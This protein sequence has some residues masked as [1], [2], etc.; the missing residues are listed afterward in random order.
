MALPVEFNTGIVEA[1]YVDLAGNPMVG[2]V[3]FS[4]SPEVLIAATSEVIVVP[5]VR[6]V[7]LDSNGHFYLELPGTDDPDIN[8]TDWT[9]RVNEV[10]PG[11]TRTYDIKVPIGQA[12]DLSTESP[13]ASANGVVITRGLTGAT[14]EGYGGG[15]IVVPPNMDWTD[16]LNLVISS[17]WGLRDDGTVYYDPQGADP[18]EAALLVPNPL[19]GQL[20]VFRPGFPYVGPVPN[21]LSNVELDTRLDDLEAVTLDPRLTALEDQHLD[22][23]LVVVSE[24]LD[25]YDGLDL[26]GRLTVVEATLVEA[27][28][29]PI[30]DTLVE[31]D[32][33]GTTHL[34]AV[35]LGAQDTG[36][37]AAVRK[38]YLDAKFGAIGKF[39][40][41]PTEPTGT[42]P[43]GSVW[44]Q[45]PS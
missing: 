1:T 31:R 14:G 19:D 13:V 37:N 29:D 7:A 9:Y 17:R 23:R 10:F 15:F 27:T 41:G 45:T 33:E 12:I 8:P 25:T 34:T 43:D 11:F 42:I 20:G 16:P 32:A 3:Q 24:R 18:A 26:D 6:E 22:E 28:S 38:D 30:P 39:Y 5:I 2:L 36:P 40:V 44:F 21:G 35:Y 4:A